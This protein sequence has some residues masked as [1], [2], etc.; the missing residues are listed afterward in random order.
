MV[1]AALRLSI[2]PRVSKSRYTKPR[3]R[4]GKT[5]AADT[6]GMLPI[7]QDMR[8][9]GKTRRTRAADEPL[10]AGRENTNA[11]NDELC[12]DGG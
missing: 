3:A 1:Y 12:M 4:Y 8:T 6:E 5:G 9:R 7:R 2:Q 11:R 10:S